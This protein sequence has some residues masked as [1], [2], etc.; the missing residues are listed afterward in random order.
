[1]LLFIVETIMLFYMAVANPL[2]FVNRRRRVFMVNN[3]VFFFFL[4]SS[5]KREKEEF[6]LVIFVSLGMISIN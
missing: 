3:L 4:T 2:G 1:V 5:Y 6:K